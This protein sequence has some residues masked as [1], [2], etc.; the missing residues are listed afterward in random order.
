MTRLD[1]PRDALVLMAQVSE[2]YPVEPI[3][4]V[5][6]APVAAAVLRKAVAERWTIDRILDVADELD[7]GAS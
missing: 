4:R 7:G 5:V 2:V 6:V 1:V 3:I